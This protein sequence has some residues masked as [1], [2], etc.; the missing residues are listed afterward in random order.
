M[1][2]TTVTLYCELL[3]ISSSLS[4]IVIKLDVLM[5]KEEYLTSEQLGY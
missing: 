3:I 5:Y 1:S 2:L 4:L